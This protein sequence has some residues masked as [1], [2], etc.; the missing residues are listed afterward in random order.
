MN[1]YR[2]LLFLLIF[3]GC[4]FGDR[5]QGFIE[6]GDL[7]YSAERILMHKYPEIIDTK[8]SAEINDNFPDSTRLNKH[9]YIYIHSHYFPGTKKVDFV[10]TSG[11]QVMI[12]NEERGLV[13]ELLFD[14][15]L[16]ITGSQEMTYDKL[17]HFM[18]IGEKVRN[19]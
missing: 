7:D 19:R 2:F 18:E 15:E 6:K 4:N 14:S 9:V 12:D 17:A 10:D 13:W 8:I 16:K 3:S 11:Y 1:G 5:P